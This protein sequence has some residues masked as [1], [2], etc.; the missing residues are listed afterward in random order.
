MAGWLQQLAR[1]VKTCRLYDG[2]NP[3]VRLFR[4]DLATALELVLKEFGPLQI[5]FT[6]E[7]IVLGESPLYSAR[8]REDNLSLP[9][10]RDGIRSMSLQPGIPQR[11]VDALVDAFLRVTHRGNED[12]DLV[13]LLWECDLEHVGIEYVSTEGDV[14]AGGDVEAEAGDLA[15]GPLAPWPKTAPP[16]T[17]QSGGA[18]LAEVQEEA[19]FD[20]TGR[21]DDRVTSGRARAV[22]A[23]LLGL[24]IAAGAEVERFREEHDAER[25]VPLAR[26]ALDLMT[27][28]FAHANRDEDRSELRQFLPRL[29]HE[30]VS[31]GDWSEAREC[32][33]LLRD[34]TGARDPVGAFAR[35]IARPESVTSQ[36]AWRCLDRQSAEQQETF[37]EFARELGPE[38]ADWLMYGIAE[39]QRQGLRQG[40]ARALAGI[41]E[42]NPERLAP[43][44]TDERWYVVRNVVHI[45]GLME[46]ASPI[47]L[48]K[49]ASTHHEFRVRREVVTA[50]GR[51]PRAVARPILLEMLHTADTRLFGTILHQ[52]ST[53]HDPGLAAMLFEWMEDDSFAARSE[54]AKRA[55]YQALAAVGGDHVVPLLEAHVLQ[56]NWIVRGN[57]TSRVAAIMCLARIGTPAA[58]AILERGAKSRRPE[59]SRACQ[60][61]LTT[62]RTP[63]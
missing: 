34:P 61:G 3:T 21:S 45:L 20:D 2:G 5:R 33:Y 28:C 60:A 55:V 19:A 49:S 38:G 51:A 1:T 47:G 63:V 27:A 18:T 15:T 40:L 14:E 62:L 13:T 31:S 46:S 24:E 9:F 10:F 53:A 7:E 22:E 43:W 59:V 6:P 52:L 48:L 54:E 57:E 30:S 4:R 8:S 36:H 26:G 42:E 32:L 50:L 35:D 37:F 12:S 23:A 44:L 25:T 29:L 17:G 16:G 41:V 11:E 39:S 56:G 58:R